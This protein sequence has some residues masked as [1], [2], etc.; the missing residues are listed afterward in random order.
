MPAGNKR[1]PI[2]RVESINN[3]DK[4]S[5]QKGKKKEKKLVLSSSRNS[6][7]DNQSSGQ[8][9]ANGSQKQLVVDDSLKI[10]LASVK[11]ALVDAK[12][13]PSKQKQI[14][15]LKKRK[16]K[17]SGNILSDLIPGYV[18]PMTLDSSALDEYRQK[19]RTFRAC[20]EEQRKNQPQQISTTNSSVNFKMS[21]NVPTQQHKY[22]DQSTEGDSIRRDLRVIQNRNYLDPKKF[23]KSSDIKINKHTKNS[24]LEKRFQRGTVIEGSTESIVTNRLSKKQRRQTVMEE[25]MST[26]FDQKTDY[27]K[28]TFTKIQHE[29][30]ERA[31][32]TVHMYKRHKSQKRR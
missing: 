18:A 17:N 19:K 5:A 6:D 3:N 13:A 15:T 2:N 21:R 24:E 1:V 10:A 31:A 4:P 14:M 22:A 27:V 25:M 28:K 29:K 20:Q 12:T 26:V 32:K 30:Q 11:Q 23:Y 7:N 9:N 8:F 16:Q